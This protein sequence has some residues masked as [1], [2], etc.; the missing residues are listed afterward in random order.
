MKN[1]EDKRVEPKKLDPSYF[2]EENGRIVFTE[3][4]HTNRGYCCGNNC[5]HCPFEPR[6]ERGNT[7][8]KK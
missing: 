7:I 6:A 4:Y 3:N 8:L 1:N 5:R 2:Y